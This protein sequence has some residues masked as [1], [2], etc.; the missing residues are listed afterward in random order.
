MRLQPEANRLLAG[1]FAFSYSHRAK[2][3]NEGAAGTRMLHGRLWSRYPKTD[4]AHISVF[5]LVLQR[6]YLWQTQQLFQKPKDSF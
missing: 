6:N 1:E 3:A 4:K 5:Y 2:P